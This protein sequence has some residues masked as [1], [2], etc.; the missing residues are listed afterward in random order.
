MW[1]FKQSSGELFAADGT[2]RGH[3]YSGGN[4]PPHFDASAVNNPDRQN[5]PCIGPLPRGVYTIGPAHTEPRLGPVAMRLTPD[6]KN[7]MQGRSDFWIHAPSPAHPLE[8]SEGCIVLD[9][10][11]RREIAASSDRMLTVVA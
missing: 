2:L 1:T 8:S 9:A 11:P 6:P 4:I 5:E 7:A 10:A 3:G